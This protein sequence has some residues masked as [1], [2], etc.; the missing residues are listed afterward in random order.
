MM[1]QYT[2]ISKLKQKVMQIYFGGR[3]DILKKNELA[4]KKIY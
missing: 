2:T 4:L 3:G 1:K